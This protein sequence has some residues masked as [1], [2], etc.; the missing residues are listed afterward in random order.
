MDRW[1]LDRPVWARKRSQ[2]G[3]QGRLDAAAD[4]IA[5]LQGLNKRSTPPA[6]T[7]GFVKLD[8][9]EQ[10]VQLNL[11]KIQFCLKQV[12]IR[13]QSVELGVDA[14]LVSHVG[15]PF[16]LLKDS[17]KRLLLYPGF[18]RSLVRDQCVGNFSERSLNSLLILHHSAVPLGFRQSHRRREPA[19]SKDGLAQLWNKAPGAI[20][21]AEKFG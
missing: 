13:I 10:L 18:P 8:D 2:H 1:A 17:N 9:A 14:P 15:Q 11:A 3:V 4:R 6:A 19:R 21:A 20:R 12:P 7:K 16:P 5:S